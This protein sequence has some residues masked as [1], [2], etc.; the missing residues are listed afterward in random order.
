[1]LLILIFAVVSPRY[2]RALTLPFYAMR[3]FSAPCRFRL[4][5]AAAATC[6]ILRRAFHFD[7]AYDATS[8]PIAAF[9]F[10]DAM[11]MLLCCHFS[12]YAAIAF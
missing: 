7:F 5:H 4:F 9:D 12:F 6:L 8:P 2:F 3:R 1:L 11:P 10:H